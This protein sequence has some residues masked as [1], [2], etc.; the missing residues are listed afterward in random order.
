MRHPFLC[1][2]LFAC[3]FCASGV[4]A[5][6]YTVPLLV[7]ATTADASQGV[8]RVLKGTTDSGAV[9]IYAIDDTG[10]R[11]GPATFTLNASE[12]VEFTATDL[13][14]GNATLGLTGGIGAD[15]GHARLEI[16]TDLQIVPLAFVRATD[17]TLS[18]MHDTVRAASSDG[19]GPY[20]Y[21]VPVFNPSTEMTQV[22]RLRLINPGDTAASVTIGGLDDSGAEATGGEVTLTIAAAGAQ[23]LTAQQLEAGDTALTG[24]LGAGTGKWRLTI[25]SDQP[26]EVVNIVA[27]AAGYWNNLST[28]AAG[29]PAPADHD[30]ATERFDGQSIVYETDAGSF[31]LTPMADGR[32]TETGESDGVTTTYMGDYSYTAIGPDAGRL[33]VDYDDGDRC[34]ANLYFSTRTGG[35]FASHCTGSDYPPEGIWLGGNWSVEGYEDGGSGSEVTERTYGVDDVLPGVPA[36]GVFAPARSSGGL[37][38]TATADGTTIA[39]DDGAY[40]E[41]NDGTRY[42]CAAADGCT[43]VNGTVTAGT[44]TGRAAGTGEVDRFPSF[45]GADNPG[46]QGYTVDTAID[47]LTLPEASVGNGTLTYS[48]SPEVPGLSFDGITRALTGTPTRAGTYRMT[49]AVSDADGDSDSLAFQIRVREPLRAGGGGGG[50]GSGGSDDGLGPGDTF[51]D[52]L[53]SGGE[54]PTMVVI[55]AGSFRMGCLNDDGRCLTSYFP[56]HAV[57]VPRFAL[58]RYEVTFAQWDACLDAGGCN[59]YRA[60]DRGWGR[61]N[62]PVMRIRWSDAQAYVAWLSQQTGEQYRLPSES[63]WEYA[64]RAGS[65]TRYHWGNAIGANRAN[66]AGCGSQWDGEMTAPVGSFGPNAWGLY[67]MHGNVLEWTADC[68]NISYAGAPTDGSAWLAGDCGGRVV[69]SGGWDSDPRWVRAVYRSRADPDLTVDVIGFRVV[70][71]LSR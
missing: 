18:A 43:I 58:S 63:E 31:T 67:D 62:R 29:G 13:Q 26:L 56:V 12:A 65:E 45:R 36:A 16:E 70:R 2:A 34:Q 52:T 25:S 61:G 68:N 7:P 60:H 44:V 27:S 48:L 11:S 23:T 59:G 38:I 24:Q 1:L 55:P 33:K 42:T 14:S 51:T 4:R 37:Q 40:F 46:T 28:T 64:A 32:F 6:R 69:R 66:C 41:L 57:N 19:S 8:L 54:G 22:S 17:G 39:L 20:R 15:A 53:A 30:A 10:T 49:Y 35:W 47:T 5:E 50:S 9:S 21:E 71:T 3:L